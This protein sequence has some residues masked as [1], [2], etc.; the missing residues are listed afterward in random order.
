MHRVLAQAIVDEITSGGVDADPVFKVEVWGHEPHDFTRT[1]EIAAK[2]DNI[3]A[4][5][6]IQRFTDEMEALSAE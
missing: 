4:Q 2:S 3:A 6:G 5:Q 1:Y